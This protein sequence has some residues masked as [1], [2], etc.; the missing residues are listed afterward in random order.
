M[1][2]SC[3]YRV[4]GLKLRVVFRA[5]E[6]CC[7]TDQLGLSRS[8]V[9]VTSYHCIVDCYDGFHRFCGLRQETN[10]LTFTDE[11]H[12]YNRAY[13]VRE[14]NSS[15][16]AI[17]H[18]CLADKKGASEACFSSINV[19]RMSTSSCPCEVCGIM[20]STVAQLMCRNCNF[21]SAARN[22]LASHVLCLLACF[23]RGS[24]F[25]VL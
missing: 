17:T 16:Y 12:R 23:F 4:A 7:D 22:A 9:E 1:L 8:S 11:I 6:P 25:P 13:C 2:T 5:V 10:T 19:H 20:F 14:T 3:E 18:S 15:S 21:A 24:A